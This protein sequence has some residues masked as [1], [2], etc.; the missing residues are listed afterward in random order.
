MAAAGYAHSVDTGQTAARLRRDR[1]RARIAIT[2][3][4]R[5]AESLG[6]TCRSVRV[7]LRGSGRWPVARSQSVAAA[8]R[9]VLIA[10]AAAAAL[11]RAAAGPTHARA[12]DGRTRSGVWGRRTHARRVHVAGPI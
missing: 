7:H 8:R 11:A 9:C 2:V 12:I 4:A 3:R 5:T 6:R 10:G 1:R